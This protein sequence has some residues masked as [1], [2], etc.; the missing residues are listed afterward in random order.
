[1]LNLGGVLVLILIRAGIL[2]EERWEW[3]WWWGDVFCLLHLLKSRS[4]RRAY[5]NPA[6]MATARLSITHF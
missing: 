2:F 6:L 5:H 3:W 4:A 1:M